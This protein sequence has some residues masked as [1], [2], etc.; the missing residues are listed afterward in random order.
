MNDLRAMPWWTGA[1]R[2]EL[3]VYVRELVDDVYEHR[4]AC[5]VCYLGDPCPFVRAAVERVV[6]WR[7]E[8][9]LRSRAAWLRARQDRLDE[10]S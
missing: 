2:A 6:D 1:D 4:E 7:D 10:A 9:M 3:D 5:V 8:R